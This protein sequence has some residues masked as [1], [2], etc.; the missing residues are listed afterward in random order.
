MK[1]V[2]DMESFYRD[3]HLG[4][5]RQAI[6]RF[7]EAAPATVLYNGS[8]GGAAIGS[9]GAQL[10]VFHAVQHFITTMDSLKLEMKA[11]DELHPNVMDLMES[12]NKVSALP[13]DHD[14][15]TKVKHWLLILGSMKAHD[16]LTPEQTRQ[17]SFDL[18]Q[19]YNAF[20]RFV[21]GGDS[22]K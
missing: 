18:E 3:Y 17:M 6:Q 20:H 13:P 2:T 5:C 4:T 7:K 14:S 1:E 11:V 15:K 21:E 22:K 16:E 9:K 8:G 19:A 10:N 12:I